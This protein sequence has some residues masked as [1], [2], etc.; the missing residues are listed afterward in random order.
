LIQQFL[1]DNVWLA[2]LIWVVLYVSD[3]ALTL[4]AARLYRTGA[5]KHIG[6]EG[7]YELTPYFVKDIDTLRF[8]SPRFL[9]ALVL[10]VLFIL[11]EWGLFV[12]FGHL[13]GAF[14]FVLGMLYL[15]EAAIHLR[16]WHNLYVFRQ[17]RHEGN[18][19]GRIEYTKSFSLRN[20]A[21][22][23]W[24]FSA[25]FLALAL[26][27]GSWFLAGGS[28]SCL[29]TG[30]QHWRLAGRTKKTGPKMPADRQ[31]PSSASGSLSSGS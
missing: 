19:T 4:S 10:S 7:S 31:A 2:I 23:V 6:F 26:V 30:I 11:A 8:L 9:L 29:A 27:T 3:Y 13:P 17:C 25:L 1:I 24:G 16:H 28:L 14:L 15:V 12:P 21:V 5:N 20:S 18:V 22:Q